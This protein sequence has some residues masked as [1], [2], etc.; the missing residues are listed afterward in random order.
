MDCGDRDLKRLLTDHNFRTQRPLVITQDCFITSSLGIFLKEKRQQK[1]KVECRE[2]FTAV[3]YISWQKLENHQHVQNRRVV[4]KTK[5]PLTNIQIAFYKLKK[6]F[7]SSGAMLI[8]RSPALPAQEGAR[9][10]GAQMVSAATY[11]VS[12]IQVTAGINEELDQH[13][14]VVPHSEMH[15]RGTLLRRETCGSTDVS[16]PGLPGCRRVLQ[17]G[18][19][20]GY[21]FGGSLR[22]L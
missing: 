18:S 8:H 2:T 17:D 11:V 19:M 3:L 5:L 14:K 6:Q 16:L 21:G 9:L 10:H 1:E 12:G 7:F 4:N 13:G 15:W 22:Y 20:A